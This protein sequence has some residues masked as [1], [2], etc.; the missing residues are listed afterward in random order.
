[1][2]P[3][4]EAHS[5][6]KMYRIGEIR[7]RYRT[8]RESASA[9]VRSPLSRFRRRS[10][11]T[12]F[13]WALRDVSFEVGAGEVIGIIGRN[14][15]GKSTLL[16]VLTRITEPTSGTAELFGRVASLLEV[17]TGFHPELTGRENVYLN[18]AILGMK[19]NEIDRAFDGIISFA[20]VERFVD[21]P[22]KHYSTGMYMRLAFAVAVHL[23]PEILLIDEVLAVGDAEFQKKCFVKMTDAARSG[24]TI[25]F[26]SHNMSAMRVICKRGLW[27]RSGELAGSGPIDE[28]VDRYLDHERQAQ[29]NRVELE[30]RHFVVEEISA[31]S[32]GSPVIKTFAPLK[33]SV[34]FRPKQ[35]IGDLNVYFGVL[36]NF[37]TR[38]A[39]LDLKD[40]RTLPRLRANE[41]VTVGFEVEAWPFLHGTYELEIHLKDMSAGIIDVVPTNHRFD[42]VETPVYG[43][44]K[45]D[46][47]FGSVGLKSQPFVSI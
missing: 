31:Q 38:L 46:S 27:L 21:T 45:L 15:A 26:V 41:R 40:F 13:V 14:G 17:G 39:G 22:V 16:K 11:K 43:S 47:W 34:T 30:T 19:K 28:L 32:V 9:W 4:I 36:T 3:I 1:M 10:D 33:L 29:A 35:D 8:L 6:S 2:R 12:P 25:L 23:E 20:E 42:V 7:T 44:R 24:R 5:I 18:G 37:Q